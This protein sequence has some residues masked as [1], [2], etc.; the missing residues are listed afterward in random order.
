MADVDHVS[1]KV[2]AD[3]LLVELDDKSKVAIVLSEDDLLMLMHA[4]RAQAEHIYTDDSFDD[5]YRKRLRE[6][7]VDMK[8]LHRQAFVK[9]TFN[10]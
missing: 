5:Q 8:Q 2:I 4:C 7:L 3:K 1:R 10:D 9:D 6:M